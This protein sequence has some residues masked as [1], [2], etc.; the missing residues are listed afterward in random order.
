[1]IHPGRAREDAPVVDAAETESR[2]PSPFWHDFGMPTTEL[3]PEVILQTI[4]PDGIGISGVEDRIFGNGTGAASG[5]TRLVTVKYRDGR[6]MQMVRKTFQPLLSGPHAEQSSQQDHWA[7]WRRELCAYESGLL[8]V[9]HGLRAPKLFGAVNDVLYIQYAGE[10]QPPANEAARQLG[11]WHSCDSTDLHQPWLAQHQL[12]QR[13]AVSDL[14]WSAVDVDGR[15]AAIWGQRDRYMEQLVNLSWS[16]THG[17][18]SVGNLCAEGDEVI[19]LDWATLG[20]SPVGLD[21]A[22]LALSTQDDSLLPAYLDG[23]NAR[24]D[25]GEVELGYRIA[26]SV[27]GA[28]RAHWM[29]T[30]SK[31]MPPNYS[32]FVTGHQL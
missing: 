22:H 31:A 12:A 5:D 26:V 19:A 8:P 25:D 6:A 13:L 24:F 18:F 32:D 1:M 15:F 10:R 16:I 2:R 4:D 20:S 29:A 23:L 21:L 7:Y 27:I 28:S 17:D 11:R 3:L 14:D 30:R 9:G